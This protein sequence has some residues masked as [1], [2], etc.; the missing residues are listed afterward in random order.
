[1][2]TFNYFAYGSNMDKTDLDKW[3]KKKG[4]NKIKFLNITPVILKDYKLCFNYFSIS[5]NCGAANVMEFKSSNVYGLLIKLPE[6][7]KAKIREKE[8]HP[9]YYIEIPINVE[10]FE[11]NLVKGA[12]TYKVIKEKEKKEHQPPSKYYMSLIIKNAENYK[13]PV[14]Y[15]NYIKS[16]DTMFF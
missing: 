6:K 4:Y 15:I 3:C 10:T 2:K 11:G 12:L 1:M 5:R 13:F 7:D 14:D 16:L 8:G 9:N